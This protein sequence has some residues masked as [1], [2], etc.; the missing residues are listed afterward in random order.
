V[1]KTSTYRVEPQGEGRA[2]FLVALLPDKR[3]IVEAQHGKVTITETRS[4]ESY[5]LAEGLRAEIPA[6]ATGFPGQQE[7]P[8]NIIGIVV[9]SAEATR[10]GNPL[11]SGGTVFEGDLVSTGATGRTVIQLSPTNQVTLNENTSARFTRIVER[12]W[13]RLQ[14]GTVV[15]ENKGKNSVLV[16][17]ARFYIEPNSTADSRIYVGVMT[18]NSTYI[19]SVAG[20]V[21]IEEIQSEQAYLLRAGQNTLVPANVSGLPGLEPLPASVAPTPAQSTPPSNPQPASVQKPHSHKTIII[22]GAAA[23]AG[24]VAAVADLA[25]GG[26]SSKPVSPSAP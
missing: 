19:E 3:T 10:N 17:T 23:G 11:A 9:A 21:R 24:I 25:A 12:V 14:K 20:D 16:A 7:E 13:L 6:S 18:D 2:E 8:S 26:G 15:A 5:T 22:L 1:V 4:G